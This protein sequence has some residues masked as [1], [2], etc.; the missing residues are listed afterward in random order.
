MELEQFSEQT[1]SHGHVDRQRK[2][3]DPHTR[4]PKL[5]TVDGLVVPSGRRT[6]SAVIHMGRRYSRPGPQVG[7]GVCRAIISGAH[8][9]VMTHRSSLDPQKSGHT[10]TVQMYRRLQS[11]PFRHTS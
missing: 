4:V 8:S 6:S 2:Q 11:H 3:P 10:Q 5:G 7:P 9:A 1:K